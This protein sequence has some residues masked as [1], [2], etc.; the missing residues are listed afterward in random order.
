MPNIMALGPGLWVTRAVTLT[1]G[2]QLGPYEIV[3]PIGAGGMGEV[4]RARDTKLDRDVAIKVLP[5]R[6]SRD[7]ESLS[8][9]ERE[10]KAVAA[11]SHPNILAIHDFGVDRGITYL[12]MELLDGETLRECLRRSALPWR[13]AIEIGISLADGLASAHEKG[14]IHRDLKPENIYLTADGVVK[15]LDFGL[16]R[17]YQPVSSDDHTVTL[18]TKP[19]T[20]MGTVNYMSPEQILGKPLDARTDIF[21]FGCVLYEMITGKRAFTGDSSPETMTAILKNQPPAPAETGVT[22]RLD[23]DQVISRCLEK[24]PQQRFHSALDLA[25]TLRNILGATGQTPSVAGQGPAR[26]RTWLFLLVVPLLFIV[27]GFAYLFNKR[28]QAP[29]DDAS[30]TSVAV[31]PLENLSGESDQE[32]FAD[33][34]TEAL[35]TDLA[36]ISALRVTSPTSVWQYKG[37]RLPLSQIA[38]ELNG[39]DAFIAGSVLRAGSRIRITVRLIEVDRDSVLWTESYEREMSDILSMQSDV[40]R[41]IAAEIRVEVTPAEH[42]LLAGARTVNPEAHDAYLMGL[43]FVRRG[44]KQACRTALRLFDDAISIDPDFALA[45]AAK[46]DAYSTLSGFH[47]P[48]NETQPQAKAA[49]LEALARDEYLA[50]AHVALGNYRLEYEWNFAG[51]EE[52]FLRAVEL[53]PSLTDAR[54]GYAN[55]L[56]AMK[57]GDEALDQLDLIQELDPAALYTFEN[58]GGAL[59]MT[60]NYLRT[61]RD[62]RAALEVDT[63]F[64]P[65]HM[66]LGWALAQVGEYSES[67]EHLRQAWKLNDE[68]TLIAASLGGILANAGQSQEAREILAD[69]KKTED[70]NYVCPYELATISIGLGDH[71]EAFAEMH[72][73]CDGRAACMPWLQVDPRLDPLR[74]DPRF[75]EVLVC[76]GFE[77]AGQLLEATESPAG[78]PVSNE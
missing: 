40:A 57:R 9:F 65:A 23:L 15:I 47:V 39:V 19:G 78:K 45:Y 28:D 51:A 50:E 68:S 17:S 16:A 6:L 31:L 10:A 74:S 35:I 32:Y 71:D 73:A 27:A 75:D 41:K 52:S 43:S 5:Q 63:E 49:A 2:K 3:A 59:F 11:L 33:G 56:V 48:P 69:L 72:R 34:M 4:Y 42:A 13:K 38:R 14:I 46:A 44:T 76:V 20:V 1:A 55:Y 8:R 18:D 66:W 36:G 26:T 12:V 54:L 25:F 64:W 24:N 53:N 21:S 58:Y 37:S 60:H 30:I 70:E 7:Q 29:L 22:T 67:I 62:C 77:P 61:I